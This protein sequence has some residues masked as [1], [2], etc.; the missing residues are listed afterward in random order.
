MKI[1]SALTRAIPVLAIGILS[2]GA[3]HADGPFAPQFIPHA[4]PGQ[5]IPIKRSKACQRTDQNYLVN[6]ADGSGTTYVS[7]IDDNTLSYSTISKTASM[8]GEPLYPKDDSYTKKTL[9]ARFYR[10]LMLKDEAKIIEP[11]IYSYILPVSDKVALATANDSTRFYGKNNPYRTDT[12]K[13]YF[14]NLDGKLTKPERPGMVPNSFYYIG[15][16]YSG[17]PA[18]VFER[19][20]INEA[21]G[22]LTVRQFDGYGNERAVFDN[23]LIHKRKDNYDSFEFSF[24]VNSD[25]KTFTVSA[26]HPET[27]EP[28]SLWFASDGS[29]IGYRPPVEPRSILIND[30]ESI[31]TGL[32]SIVGQ[33][34]VLT[35]LKDDRL[36][37]PV[38]GNGEKIPAPDNFIGMARLFHKQG[39]VGSVS[40]A[41]NYYSKWVLVYALPTGYGFKTDYGS[42]FDSQGIRSAYGVLSAENKLKMFSGF[43]YR[44]VADGSFAT[45]LRPF[46]QYQEDGVTPVERALPTVW[47]QVWSSSEHGMSLVATTDDKDPEKT[48]TSSTEAFEAIG[49]ARVAHDRAYAAR[50]AASRKAQAEQQAFY[51]AERARRQAE[52]QAHFAK[53]AQRKAELMAKNKYRPKTGAEEFEERMKLMQNHWSQK[54]K[55]NLAPG[56]K[57]CYDMGDGSDFCFAY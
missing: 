54:N 36:Y 23:I 8:L 43:G 45:I 16:Y 20:R 19:V 24:Y 34:P 29:V 30:K 6:K 27:G 35:D 7:I 21:R 53:E 52:L 2:G 57:I 12:N 5:C 56:T 4:E 41:H 11:A 51:E 1:L 49:R 26:L 46:D 37:H 50:V 9:A 55:P 48:F 32:V 10:G 13:F 17:M 28:A 14:V 42:D 47:S 40:T 25:T 22:T 33:L 44:R 15:G 39:K 18:H 31:N 3:A 38:D